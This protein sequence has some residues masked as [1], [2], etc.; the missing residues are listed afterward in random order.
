M[1][2]TAVITIMT[3]SADSIIAF[4]F[5]LPH[6]FTEMQ[7][8]NLKHHIPEMFYLWMFEE[9]T[10]LTTG[11]GIPDHLDNSDISRLIFYEPIPLLFYH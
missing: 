10:G 8:L 1:K 9:A 5:P 4:L 7:N 3:S 6:M 11:Q 2:F